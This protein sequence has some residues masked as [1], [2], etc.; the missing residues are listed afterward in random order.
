[1]AAEHRRAET[2][3]DPGEGGG[4]F[5]TQI[6]SKVRPQDPGGGAA[7]ITVPREAIDVEMRSL[8]VSSVVQPQS[9]PSRISVVL[10]EESE[11]RGAYCLASGSADQAVRLLAGAMCLSSGTGCKAGAMMPGAVGTLSPSDSESVGPVGLFGT[12]SPSD[13]DYVGPAGPYGT[14][15]PSDSEFV[16]LL[17]GT[18]SVVWDTVPI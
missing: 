12:L 3:T 9:V 8:S 4:G 6:S 5:A 11:V 16:A 18:L 7:R 2:V 14:L 1:M 15:F 13:S 10:V 17:Y